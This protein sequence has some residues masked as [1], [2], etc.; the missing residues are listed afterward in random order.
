[1]SRKNKVGLDYFSHDTDMSHD[2]KL[3]FIR[4]K[5]GLIG[6]AVFNIL[7]EDIYKDKGYFLILDDRYLIL[8]SDENKI[9]INVCRNLINDYINEGLFNH[10]LF[11]KFKVL[12]SRR[13]Q[14]NYLKGCE[15][16]KT[17]EFLKKLL[18][19]DP[20]KVLPETNNANIIIINDNING[21]KC[22]HN[23]NIK[24]TLMSKVK[25][26]KEEDS[27]EEDS[28][29]QRAVF[30]F[31]ESLNNEDF[32]NSFNE[33]KDYRKEIK[34]PLTDSTIKKQL[35]FLSKQPDPVAVI[36]NSITNSWQG[37]FE[38]KNQSN[39]T[40]QTNNGPRA[41]NKNADRKAG[42]SNQRISAANKIVC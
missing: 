32:K 29:E 17:I 18:L 20:K 28:K 23:V 4:A 27:K 41:G 31:P 34:K 1:M 26:S 30:V 35:I 16:R 10:L 7:L 36:D 12:T 3:K 42:Q 6:Y 24:H 11:K 38:I 2:I 14:E 25:K 21:S 40:T 8:F 13:I 33:W 22:K 5:H 37:L 19:I 39:G 15:R 9:D